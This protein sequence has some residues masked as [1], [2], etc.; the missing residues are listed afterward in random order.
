LSQSLKFDSS[1]IKASLVNKA[2]LQSSVLPIIQSVNIVLLGLYP[3]STMTILYIIVAMI[4][5]VYVGL[6]YESEMTNII[7]LSS[8]M[9]STNEKPNKLKHSLY[10]A[11][12]KFSQLN[13]KTQHQTQDATCR[14]MHIGLSRYLVKQASAYSTSSDQ[15]SN[16]HDSNPT[17]T[18]PNTHKRKIQSFINASKRLFR[19]LSNVTSISSLSVA[20]RRQS[21]ADKS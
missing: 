19:D 11:S 14:F 1:E 4:N 9:L 16:D 2:L 8:W 17:L 18:E 12:P 15:S 3:P 20:R 10:S 7:L 13:V 5:I 21:Q 6:I